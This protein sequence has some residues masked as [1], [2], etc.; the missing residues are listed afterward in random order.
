MR[1]GD[2]GLTCW[3]F[4]YAVPLY[5]QAISIIIPPPT[6]RDSS[7]EDKCRGA[8]SRSYCSLIHMTHFAIHTRRRTADEQ[9]CGT[10]HS[11]VPDT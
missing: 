4:R 10:P 8:S 2:I 7:P 11:D 5:L 9:P 1:Q 6:R 3:V